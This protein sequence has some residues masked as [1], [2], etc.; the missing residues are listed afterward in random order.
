MSDVKTLTLEQ[1]M[2]CALAEIMRSAWDGSIDHDTANEALYRFD[3][4]SRD[5]MTASDAE[6]W[7][8]QMDLDEG[9]SY[10][11]LDADI[12]RL[13]KSVPRSMRA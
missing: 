8:H 7:G 10:D 4:L 3:L 12:L 13:E 5:V 2:A 6:A 11:R 9:D 1:R